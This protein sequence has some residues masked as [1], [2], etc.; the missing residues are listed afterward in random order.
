MFLPFKHLWCYYRF[1]HC[2]N[3][4]H[5][6]AMEVLMCWKHNLYIHVCPDFIY[7]LIFNFSNALA[8]C[9]ICSYIFTRLQ[10]LIIDCTTR[11]FYLSAFNFKGSRILGQVRIR[12]REKEHFL[13]PRMV[14]W[15]CMRATLIVE[16]DVG[17]TVFKISHHTW[18]IT[19]TYAQESPMD[20][21]SLSAA[22]ISVKWLVLKYWLSLS[23]WCF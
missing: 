3:T 11:N 7:I 23:W 17:T 21:C 16:V 12:D 20:H 10:T 14:W 8:K 9:F 5:S 6:I 19:S 1:F 13:G 2:M 15:Q 22:Y 18:R 4:F